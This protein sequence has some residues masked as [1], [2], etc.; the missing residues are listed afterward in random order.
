ME[1]FNFKGGEKNK[2][3]EQLVDVYETQIRNSGDAVYIK[4]LGGLIKE[5]YEYQG[6]T[7]YEIP[8]PDGNMDDRNIGIHYD[9]LENKVQKIIEFF[10][11]NQ[12]WIPERKRMSMF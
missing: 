6:L 7:D 5:R 10:D 2:T 4:A 12:P 8:E 1:E 11:K 3:L 9:M